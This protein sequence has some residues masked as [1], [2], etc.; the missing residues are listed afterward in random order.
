[1]TERTIFDHIREKAKSLPSL[2]PNSTTEYPASEETL[3]LIRKRTRK[4]QLA[5]K[6]NTESLNLTDYSNPCEESIEPEGTTSSI[7]LNG[8]AIFEHIRKKAKSFTRVDE[9]KSLSTKSYNIDFDFD[10]FI[11]AKSN[12][13][14]KENVLTL[15]SDPVKPQLK[16]ATREKQHISPSFANKKCCLMESEVAGPFR[17]FFNCFYAIKFSSIP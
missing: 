13:V 2:A 4:R 15:D 1:I 10:L 9:I 3:S 17:G 5:R 16:A 11:D 7:I 6:E 14:Q 12:I 8:D